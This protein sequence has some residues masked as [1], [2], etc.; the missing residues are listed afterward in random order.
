MNVDIIIKGRALKAMHTMS[1]PAAEEEDLRRA[2]SDLSLEYTALMT[3]IPVFDVVADNQA[4]ILIREMAGRKPA[5]EFIP[6]ESE[7]WKKAN[8]SPRSGTRVIV[9]VTHPIDGNRMRF[10]KVDDSGAAWV[11]EGQ[12][13]GEVVTHWRCLPDGPKK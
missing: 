2:L 13:A 11:V 8:E 4:D 12:K 9:L 6:D 1:N 3:G 7:R 10:G 5:K